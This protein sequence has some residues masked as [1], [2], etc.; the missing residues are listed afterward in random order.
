MQHCYDV[1][2]QGRTCWFVEVAPT[3]ARGKQRPV[4]GVNIDTGAEVSFPVS[5]E[6]RRIVVSPGYIANCTGRLDLR[7]HRGKVVQS[8]RG[9]EA[10]VLEG[11]DDR[12]DL[13][14]S[15]EVKAL[16]VHRLRQRTDQVKSLTSHINSASVS[17]DGSLIVAETDKNTLVVNPTTLVTRTLTLGNHGHGA[18]NSWVWAADSRLALRFADPVELLE[19]PAAKVR[20]RFALRTLAAA[21]IPG[22]PLLLTSHEDAIHIWDTTTGETLGFQPHGATMLVI[23]RDGK[24]LVAGHS[25]TNEL[26]VWDVEDLVNSK[27]GSPTSALTQTPAANKTAATRPAAVAKSAAGKRTAARKAPV[28]PIVEVVFG[29]DAATTDTQLLAALRAAAVDYDEPLADLR[30]LVGPVVDGAR[31]LTFVGSARMN[32]GFFEESL[33]PH[34]TSLVRLGRSP[35]GT[36]E[37]SFSFTRANEPVL[38]LVSDGTRLGLIRGK[39]RAKGSRA[40]VEQIGLEAIGWS[41]KPAYDALDDAPHQVVMHAAKKIVA[42]PK[43]EPRKPTRGEP[44]PFHPGC[45]GLAARQAPARPERLTYRAS[46]PGTRPST[47]SIAP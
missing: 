32:A 10:G 30:C 21:F 36:G 17:P 43:L 44:L 18:R 28:L 16:R 42:K 4:R 47:T 8:L 14:V 45:A 11:I 12:E 7:D 31:W 6:T 22:T 5:E 39:L 3:V 46:V 2:L 27:K 24:R 34:V 35:H 23:S 37:G 13:A 29:I 19:M 38:E 9:S 26:L 41:T 40:S 20:W 15:M 1:H 33:A 25:G